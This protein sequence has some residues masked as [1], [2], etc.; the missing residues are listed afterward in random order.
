MTNYEAE[1]RLCLFGIP[2]RSAEPE[3]VR[4]ILARILAEGSL[5][6]SDLQTAR[7]VVEHDGL[8]TPES[9]LFLPRWNLRYARA[10]PTS[11]STEGRNC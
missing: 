4:E 5:S 2:A 10:I 7:D 1:R 8:K 3:K 11:G 6:L 9:Y